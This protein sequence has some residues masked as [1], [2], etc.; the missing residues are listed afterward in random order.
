LS[1]LRHPGRAARPEADH[2]RAPRARFLKAA[3]SGAIRRALGDL[4][5]V[6]LR[7][8][9]VVQ[10]RVDLEMLARKLGAIKEYEE[11]I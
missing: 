11:T 10:K 9:V 6:D 1:G 5:V 7:T 2:R 4:F 8:K 3:R